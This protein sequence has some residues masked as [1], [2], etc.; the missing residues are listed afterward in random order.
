MDLFRRYFQAL[1]APDDGPVLIHC[2]SGK[3]RTGLL[4]ALTHWAVGVRED[5]LMGDF[6]ATNALLGP[7]L[8]GLRKLASSAAGREVGDDELLARVSVGPDYLEAAFGSMIE[9]NGS[10]DG[11]LRDVLGLDAGRKTALIDRLVA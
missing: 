9:R 3:D 6:L 8:P 7:R 11:Y 4:A 1:V 2:A 10:V 5:D